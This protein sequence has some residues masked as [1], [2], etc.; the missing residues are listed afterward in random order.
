[1]PTD[2][3]N[4]LARRSAIYAELAAMAPGRAGGGPNSAKA[5]IDHARYKQW[6][7]NELATLDAR[8]NA[9]DG[10]WDMAS[11]AIP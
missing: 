10:P 5:G 7:L 9:V 11:E 1:M 6:L 8:I 3:E 4:L 2:L